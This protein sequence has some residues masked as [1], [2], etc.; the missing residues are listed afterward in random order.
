MPIFVQHLFVAGN[1][2]KQAIG[3][4]H[5]LAISTMGDPIQFKIYLGHSSIHSRE[6]VLSPRATSS[7]DLTLALFKW[8]R[9]G[10]LGRHSP[11]HHSSQGNLTSKMSREARSW[12]LAIPKTLGHDLQEL[13]VLS[14]RPD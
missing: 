10:I 11:L 8:D 6:A 1:V 5:V 2:Y 13:S 14:R 9:R 12:K 3:L 7:R 4:G